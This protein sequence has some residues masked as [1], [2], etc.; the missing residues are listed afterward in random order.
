[1]VSFE[2]QMCSIC[3]SHFH[4]L[5]FQLTFG[6]VSS[7]WYTLR[8]VAQARIHRGMRDAFELLPLNIR[9]ERLLSF[10]SSPVAGQMRLRVLETLRRLQGRC[11][12][13]PQSTTLASP[14]TIGMFILDFETLMPSIVW[15]AGG[16][17]LLLWPRAHNT[18]Q[19]C[20][21]TCQ[22]FLG[23]CCLVELVDHVD[24]ESLSSSREQSDV[25]AASYLLDGWF[26]SQ[27]LHFH[28]LK[29]R[30]D[31]FLHFFDAGHLF[32]GKCS[33]ILGLRHVGFFTSDAKNL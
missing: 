31:L 17:W 2:S 12:S 29:I 9:L 13:K 23:T 27:L 15:Y 8:R 30:L 24:I 1:M 7:N 19:L 6:G 11:S 26:C 18:Y 33:A 10:S 16:A 22:R 25:L 21:V 28:F 5:L 20:C 3:R 4:C 32:S 14:L